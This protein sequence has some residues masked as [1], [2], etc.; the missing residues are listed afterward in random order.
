MNNSNYKWIRPKAK[1]M[2]IKGLFLSILNLSSRITFINK[3]CHSFI[4]STMNAV[5]MTLISV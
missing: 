4:L 1:N 5:C 2:L 3:R